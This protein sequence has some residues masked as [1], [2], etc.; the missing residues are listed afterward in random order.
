MTR[1]ESQ[2]SQAIFDALKAEFGVGTTSSSRDRQVFKKPSFVPETRPNQKPVRRW[3]VGYPQ[4][5]KGV[6]DNNPVSPPK[7]QAAGSTADNRNGASTKA[8][9]VNAPQKNG[10]QEAVRLPDTSPVDRSHPDGGGGGDDD[11]KAVTSKIQHEERSVTLSAENKSLLVSGPKMDG[12]Q[13]TPTQVNED[14]DYETFCEPLSPSPDDCTQ[15]TSN[16]EPRTLD[17]DDTGAVNFGNLSELPRP[18]SQVSEDRGFENSCGQWR[19]STDATTPYKPRDGLAALETPAFALSK[20]PFGT[21]MNDS[22]VPF[23]GTQLFGQTQMLS[24]A[25]KLATPSS[26]LPSPVVVFNL[27]ETSPL[28]N[29][30]NVSSPT[31]MHSSSPTMVTEILDTAPRDNDFTIVTGETP[32]PPQS[33]KDDLIPES[34][35]TS[36][37]AVGYQPMAYYEPMRHSQ[38]RK[39]SDE[40][41]QKPSHHASD[42]EDETFH[43]L[44]RKRRVERKRAAAAKEMEKVSFVRTQ[45]KPLSPSS[46]RPSKRRKVGTAADQ[47]HDHE[48]R[49]DVMIPGCVRDSQKAPSQSSQLPSLRP[50][51]ANPDEQ[52]RDVGLQGTEEAPADGGLALNA[53]NSES[54]AI[55][56]DD[57]IPATSPLRSSSAVSPRGAPSAS[58]PELPTLSNSEPE[59]EP[60]ST[61][62]FS[63]PPARQRPCRTYGRRGRAKQARLAVVSTADPDIDG[64]LVLHDHELPP[65]QLPDE[66]NQSAE[67]GK[68]EGTAEPSIASNFPHVE[69][70]RRI[71]TRSTPQRSRVFQNRAVVESSSL[72]D[73]S[74]TPTASSKTTPRADRSPIASG[75]PESVNLIS[76]ERS[77]RPLRKVTTRHTATPESPQPLTK[78]MRLS[79]RAV[80]LDSDSADELIRSPSRSNRSFRLTSLGQ[81]HRSRRLFEGMVFALSFSD[82]RTQRTKLEARITQAGG[83]IVHE[84]FQELFEPSS[85]LHANSAWQE[86]HDCLTLGRANIDCGF[87]AVIADSHSRKAKYMQALALGLPCLAPQ[88]ANMCLRKGEI[89]DWMPYLLCAGQSQVLGNAIRSRTLS[90]YDALDAKLVETLQQRDKLLDGEKL[91]II[92]DQK[93]LRRETKQ[94]YLFLALALG[95]SVICRVS[96]VQEAG[97]VIRQAERD[98]APFGWVYMDS[99]TGTMESLLAAAAQ[100]TGRKKRKSVTAD[101]V[102]GMLNVLTDELVIQSLILGRMV[103][104]DEMA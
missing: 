23:E 30:A 86:S 81:A 16:E 60:E 53:Q 4:H 10:L 99:S 19:L 72:S 26:C 29:R 21:S 90:P 37:L 27:V 100:G 9:G 66:N 45:R 68:A 103:E 56:N 58:D 79:R 59:K 75:R 98:G 57:I 63:R 87:A 96:T 8:A 104:E 42:S 64:D 52:V 71:D 93:K 95:P 69:P 7:K 3:P 43:I 14:R 28:K 12:S 49:A 44:E 24:S 38:E 17:L 48:S 77:A 74:G 76:P 50:N 102:E 1:L 5:D 46:G 11:A 22:A 83:T 70:R 84:G 25:M 88:W 39:G 82:S 97:G 40:R 61:D 20:N 2:D 54:R 65:T 35:T 15:F 13:Q 73:L 89:V 62:P 55:A 78:A 101:P 31:E 91:L 41:L 85:V 18:S 36:R 80:R 67:A 51:E 33:Q 92:M 47:D 94:Q 34:P 6:T 32:I